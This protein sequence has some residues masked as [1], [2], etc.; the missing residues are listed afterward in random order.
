MNYAVLLFRG[1]QALDVFGPLDPLNL[2]ARKYSIT[3]SIIGPSL[4]PVSTLPPTGNDSDSLFSE[5]IVP[6]HTYA[7]RPSN[8]D[9][10][11]IP[12]GSGVLHEDTIAPVIDLAQDLVPTVQTVFTV[13]TGSHVLARTGL[14]DGKH[15]TTN[16]V[17]F[18]EIS[19]LSP[20][21]QWVRKA[22]WVVQDEGRI[23]T[24]SGVSAGIDAMLA[25]LE[26]HYGKDQ[27]N[28]LAAIMEYSRAESADDDPFE[29]AIDAGLEL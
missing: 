10:L 5:S 26:G 3:L 27:V 9:V 13:C 21:V 24:S 25:F 15:A 8:I 23:W 18:N 22:R 12:G 6:T 17:R 2:L 4:S 20:A 14:L 1:F 7:S 19:R 29:W 16:K 11:I 28:T